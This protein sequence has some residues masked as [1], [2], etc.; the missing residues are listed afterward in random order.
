MA[1]CRDAWVRAAGLDL[2][3]PL[4]AL[5]LGMLWAVPA[6][7][8]IYSCIDAGGNKRTS[9]RPIRECIAR[10]QQV[11][12]PDGSVKHILP[13]VPTADERAEQEARAR[14]AAAER[15]AWQDAV[16][17]DRNLMLRFPDEAA[18][19]KARAAALDDVR[20]AVQS[21]QRRIAA[22]AADRKPLMDETEF[23][24]GKPLPHKLR[25]QLDANDAATEAQRSLIQ[26]QQSEIGRINALYDVELMRLRKLWAG[27]LPGSM[28][29]LPSPAAAASVATD[30]TSAK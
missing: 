30:K 11:L 9:D 3:L 26:N 6:S 12:N 5:A 10:E 1:E 29:P 20:A 25:Q 23:Y 7:A 4:L 17:R 22:L 27:A 21:S 28:G 24:V 18:H 13:P 8:A 15:S 19:D 14:R 2:A 16:R